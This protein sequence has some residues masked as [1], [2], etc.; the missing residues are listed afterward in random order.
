MRKTKRIISIVMV[1][2]LVVSLFAI[3]QSGLT[4]AAKSTDVVETSANEYGL[5]SNVQDGVILHAWNVSLNNI[6]A[7]LP[8]IAKAGFTTVQTSPIQQPKDY[9]ASW[10]DV[11]GQWWKL[12]QPLSLGTIAT[13]SWIGTKSELTSLCTEADKYGIKIICDIVANHLAN[14]GDKTVLNSGVRNYEE[15]FYDHQDW[16]FHSYNDC[17]DGDIVNVV[18]GNLGMPDLNT[19]HPDVQN[20]VI[21]LLEEC[22]DCGVDGFR[23]DAAKHIETPDDGYY[24]S[25]FWPNV[26]NTTTSYAQ[27]KGVTPYYYGEILSTC[28]NN[29][30]FGSYANYMSVT[31]NTTG[32]NIMW[33]VY[34]NN[35][36][37]AATPYY[38]TGL[39]ASKV[40]LWAESHDTYADDS[41]SD[42][43]QVTI[44]KAYCLDAARTNAASLYLI[45]TDGAKMGEIGSIA[46]KSAAVSAANHFHNY[47]IGSQ[48]YMSSYYDLAVCERY[49]DQQT[50]VVI[51][52]CGG[53]STSVSDVP[54][55]MMHD[56]NY[57][58]AVTGNSFTV[59]YGKLS[60]NIGSSGVAVVYD[61][62]GSYTPPTENENAGYYLVGNI[63][64]ENLWPDGDIPNDRKF[65]VNPAQSDTQ[66]YM[67]QNFRLHTNDQ[68]KVVYYDGTSYT[69]YPAGD[70]YTVP[71][72]NAGLVDVYFRPYGDG[73]DFWTADGYL[74]FQIIEAETES[75]E[76]TIETVTETQQTSSTEKETTSEYNRIYVGKVTYLGDKAP[77]IH[78]WNL[79][80]LE[81]DAEITYISKQESFSVGQSYWSNG[82][83]PFN[84]GYVDLPNE[85]TDFKAYINGTSFNDGGWASE[86]L[87][88][89]NATN[90]IACVFEYS[91]TVHNVY[92]NYNAPTEAPTEPTEKP[93]EKP[94]DA[95]TIKP[96]EPTEP[97]TAIVT[98]NVDDLKDGYYLLG[99]FN[100]VSYWQDNID[101]NN[102]LYVNSTGKNEE[103]ILY[104]YL[105]PGD[106]MKVVKVENGVITEFYKSN[107]YS[108]YTVSA[109]FRNKEGNYKI[110]FRPK[111]KSNWLYTYINASKVNGSTVPTYPPQP[112]EATEATEKPTDPV[113]EY[114]YGDANN[115][116]QITITDATII[117][118]H[119]AKLTILT[120]S[121][122]K[123]ALVLS[124]TEVAISDA[125]AIQ[126]YLARIEPNSEKIGKIAK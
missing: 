67:L 112:T 124:D 38:N 110:L 69:W 111:G 17:H 50:G 29:R 33:N 92:A 68:L 32:N 120:P 96:T 72:S 3:S 76:P 57:I 22:I 40:V 83:Q 115:D 48:E 126:R 93:T 77:K 56:G 55:Y 42:V 122:L 74:Y 27:S 121:Q 35:A 103:Y 2:S 82:A 53:T 98:T 99:T 28:G 113:V 6:K 97:S 89:S 105:Y 39:D 37:G 123:C 46:Y 87:S 23:F 104:K 84:I 95:P 20:R 41:T 71:S 8:D 100:G 73:G 30:G 75:V 85:A 88:I 12:Y 79:N 45:R 19:A 15:N 13:S 52:N 94:T 107:E 54:M 18:Q 58:D 11:S 5:A 81:G 66:E 62:N 10:T 16:Y 9:N 78:Y 44:N 26:L 63:N 70:N 49:N 60:G 59:S 31:D 7:A 117:Q 125:T 90:K 80:G 14:N 106:Q 119:L 36:A 34:G 86:E 118:R 109:N 47:F 116:G 25:N 1:I 108:N 51:V 102:K 64:G 114:Q 24:A 21:N 43:S 65:V 91:N 61:A 101:I 4:I